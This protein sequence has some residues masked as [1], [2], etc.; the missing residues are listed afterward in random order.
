M[1]VSNPQET[2]HCFQ[3]QYPAPQTVSPTV[4]KDSKVGAVKPS[5]N[6]DLIQTQHLFKRLAC[7]M[8]PG[9]V[10]ADDIPG[11]C[12]KLNAHSPHAFPSKHKKPRDKKDTKKHHVFAVNHD[13][14]ISLDYY[15]V[16][17]HV[18]QLTILR[19]L[20]TLSIPPPQKKR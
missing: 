7:P 11:I 14:K 8:Q 10:V 13:S 1:I 3:L 12:R 5:S 17:R 2:Y 20:G 6:I 18:G 19:W 9:R 4:S 16:V 15:Q